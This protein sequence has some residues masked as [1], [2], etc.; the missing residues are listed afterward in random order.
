MPAFP[1]RNASLLLQVQEAKRQEDTF[2][3]TGAGGLDAL[4]GH[5]QQ[6]H[7]AAADKAGQAKQDLGEASVTASGS[8][9]GG[10]AGGGGSGVDA[11]ELEV[12]CSSFGR[13]HLALL[14]PVVGI[15]CS[16]VVGLLQRLERCACKLQAFTRKL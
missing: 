11:E 6:L 1:E 3:L 2:K 7:A 13:S 14:E 4:Q 8:V 16:L 12:I 15:S 10:T 5:A 9:S